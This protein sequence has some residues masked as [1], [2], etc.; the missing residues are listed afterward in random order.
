HHQSH[1]FAMRQ[2]LQRLGRHRGTR[3]RIYRNGKTSQSGSARFLSYNYTTRLL[4]WWTLLNGYIGGLLGMAT[5]HPAP[6]APTVAPMHP[7]AGDDRAG[8]GQLGLEL[9]CR[10]VVFDELSPASWTGIGKQ[11]VEVPVH[12]FGGFLENGAAW[13]LPA[14]WDSSSSA[15]SSAMRA[16][17]AAT[18]SLRENTSVSSSRTSAASSPA[19]EG[20]STLVCSAGSLEDEM[21]GSD[22]SA[23]PGKQ[24]TPWWFSGGGPR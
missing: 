9:H 24:T 6:T 14:R 13:R 12:L 5:L 1:Q 4:K 16:S 2:R 22:H 21:D 17:R 3:I 7:K 8:L 10:L 20:N 15:T 23:P 18:R 19:E 11:R